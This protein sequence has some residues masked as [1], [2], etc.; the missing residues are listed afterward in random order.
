MDE[1]AARVRE[2]VRSLL[3]QGTDLTNAPLQMIAMG[4]WL[5]LLHC[6]GALPLLDETVTGALTAVGT[7]SAPSCTGCGTGRTLQEIWEF[8]KVP[9]HPARAGH[10]IKMAKS[11]QAG[12]WLVVGQQIACFV[13][14]PVAKCSRG[15]CSTCG[16]CQEARVIQ[17]EVLSADVLMLEV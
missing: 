6:T 16:G 2:E 12:V 8:R 17:Q 3:Q 15:N 1:F 9:D 11:L 14:G 5:L 7:C 13:Q 10:G 4:R